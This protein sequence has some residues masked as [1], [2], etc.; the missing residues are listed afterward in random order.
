MQRTS[1]AANRGMECSTNRKNRWLRSQDLNLRVPAVTA[2]Q[3]FDSGWA[4]YDDLESAFGVG[5]G[6]GDGSLFE[7][8]RQLI[9]VSKRSLTY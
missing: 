3:N 1:Y 7:A 5:V 8:M 2:S 9:S 6:H 4:E